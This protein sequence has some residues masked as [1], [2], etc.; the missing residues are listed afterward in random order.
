MKLIPSTPLSIS[1]LLLPLKPH[2]STTAPLPHGGARSHAMDSLH[3]Y[4]VDHPTL[5]NFEWK[6]GHTWGASTQFLTL[7]IFCYLTLTYLLSHSQIPTLHPLLLRPISAAH[8]LLLLLLSL[9]MVVG[10]SLSAASQTPD[11]RWIFCFPPDTP[12]SGPTFFWAYVF[13]LSKIVEF[14]DTFLIILSGSIKRLSFLHV[15]HHTVVLIMCYIW[16]HTSQSLMPVA[17]VT[18]ASVHVLMY[19][20]YL[21]CTLGWRPRWKRV[22]TDVQIVQFMFSFAVSGLMLYYHFSGI[23]CSGIWG[24]CFNAVFNASLLGLFLDFHFRNYARR[25]KEEKAKGS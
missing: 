7:T 16:L 25:K 3:H 8:N 23:G 20:Y 18:N 17:L 5:A 9:A 22:V 11:T 19:T 2:P 12:P 21:S 10:C 1:R 14:I 24:W 6:Q 15:Y 13:Y 4:L